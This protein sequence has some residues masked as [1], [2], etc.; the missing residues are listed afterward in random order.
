[1]RLFHT[2][3]L[4][5][6]SFGALGAIEKKDN[7]K[8]DID[9]LYKKALYYDET[10]DHKNAL[11]HYQQLITSTD[12]TDEFT[13]ASFLRYRAIAFNKAGIIYYNRGD[14]VRSLEYF[15]ESKKIHKNFDNHSGVAELNNNIGTVHFAWKDYEKAKRYYKKTLDYLNNQVHEEIQISLVESNIGLIFSEKGEYQRALDYLTSSLSNLLA[16]NP[17][18]NTVYHHTNIGNAQL[19]LGQHDKAVK[20]FKKALENGKKQNTSRYIA[21]AYAHIGKAMLDMGN[22]DSAIVY[23]NRSNE[24]ALP[25]EHKSIIYDNYL[26]LSQI[27]EQ[28]GRYQEALHYHKKYNQLENEVFNAEKH[29]QIQELLLLYETEKKE[30][31]ILALNQKNELRSHHIK[32]QN[33]IIA[34]LSVGF[35][36]IGLLLVIVYIQKKHK[37][38]SYQ[39]LVQKNFEIARN[40]IMQSSRSLHNKSTARDLVTTQNE[41]SFNG[42]HKIP[43]LNEN[44]DNRF[45][46][47]KTVLT[48]ETGRKSKS[49]NQK[50]FFEPSTLVPHNSTNKQDSNAIPEELKN[51]LKNKIELVMN[52]TR[53]YL[54]PSFTIDKLAHIVSSNSRYV[55]KIINEDFQ[56][57]YTEFINYYR[58]KEAR[59]LLSDPNYEQ[60]T[61]EAIAKMVGFKSKSSF[62]IFFKKNTGLTPSYYQKNIKNQLKDTLDIPDYIDPNPK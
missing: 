51:K 44:M 46:H 18:E 42:R 38:V 59:I 2:A 31:E 45:A 54:E 34:I 30:K 37:D 47:F 49:V 43:L 48:K 3:L 55:S 60:M 52:N 11:I 19:K 32:T 25:N 58:I 16:N 57:S 27:F 5:F 17:K 1:L 61:I 26:M 29:N 12:D 7:L 50:M 35:I 39:Q 4:F 40:Q 14:L 6:I 33:Q 22:L 20:N 13:E 41:N 62:N 21:N 24:H 56:M 53:E 9:N 36:S 23:I 28:S 15:I 8:L 10:E